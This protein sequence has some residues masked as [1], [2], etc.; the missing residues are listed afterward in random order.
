MLTVKT[1]SELTRM[2]DRSDSKKVLQL[3]GFFFRLHGV[4]ATDAK[5]ATKFCNLLSGFRGKSWTPL[6]ASPQIPSP[7]ADN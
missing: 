3:Q 2:R 4:S 7:D 1:D 5:P 6:G